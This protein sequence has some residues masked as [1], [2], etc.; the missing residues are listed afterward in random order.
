MGDVETVVEVVVWNG[1]KFRRYPQSKRRSDRVYFTPG[2]SDRA[3]GIGRLHEE[4]WKAIHGPIPPGYLIHHQ[5]ENSLNNDDDNLVCVP[6]GTHSTHHFSTWVHSPENLKRLEEIRP[7]T[8]RWHR[9]EEGHAW[10]VENGRNSWK[11][12]QEIDKA[13]E[14]CG[15]TFKTPWP[16]RA[17]FCSHRCEMTL[18]R[19]ERRDFA[20]FIC[21]ECGKHFQANKYNKPKCCSHQCAGQFRK[22]RR[23][24]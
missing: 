4:K 1:I 24:E 5:D 12:K 11:Q 15:Q 3:K 14:V 6:K 7:L 18:R 10:H 16:E 22:R 9:S 19:K 13:C 21:V 20:E 23:S 8:K 17:R 2:V